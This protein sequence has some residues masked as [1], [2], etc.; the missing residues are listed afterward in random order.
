MTINRTPHT[1]TGDKHQG[2]RT[3]EVRHIERSAPRISKRWLAYFTKESHITLY[4]SWLCLERSTLPKSVEK[5][6]SFHSEGAI[7]GS[8]PRLQIW[9]DTFECAKNAVIMLDS[10][11][12]LKYKL[13]WA[14]CRHSHQTTGNH[15]KLNISIATKR[16]REI[17]LS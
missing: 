1:M 7:L 16:Y 17:F 2:K 12:V 8:P 11:F 15:K 6:L 4:W 5:D 13:C 9:T 3:S 14:A 10:E